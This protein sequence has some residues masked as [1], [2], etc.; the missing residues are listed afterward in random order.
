[1][2]MA[3]GAATVERLCEKIQEVRSRE[4]TTTF[5][6]LIT[7]ESR[8]QQSMIR[9]AIAVTVPFVRVLN[10]ELRGVNHDHTILGCRGAIAIMGK[11]GGTRGI[12]PR[13][14]AM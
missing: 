5:C 13:I 7:E 4:A 6:R 14:Q 8:P 3:Q 11:L 2:D 9:E 12:L 1:M 10:G